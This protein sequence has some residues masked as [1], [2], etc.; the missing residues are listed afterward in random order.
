[1]CNKVFMY[2]SKILRH[3]TCHVWPSLGHNQSW[4]QQIKREREPSKAGGFHILQRG[5]P[6]LNTG[7]R[8]PLYG[9]DFCKRWFCAYLM[10]AGGMS[11][12]MIWSSVVC[13][14]S[15]PT[16]KTQSH[17][18]QQDSGSVCGAGR[19]LLMFIDLQFPGPYTTWPSSSRPLPCPSVP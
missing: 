6:D 8:L 15:L 13:T 7:E 18:H 3:L 5:V 11:L 14:V 10:K 12:F 1:M 19:R 9:A 16:W 4:L 17:H 2:H